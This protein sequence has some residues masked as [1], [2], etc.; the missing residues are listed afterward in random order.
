MDWIS[1]L[2]GLGAVISAVI[3]TA[4]QRL[5]EKKAGVSPESVPISVD[6]KLMD[7]ALR[8]LGSIQ[9]N[10]PWWKTTIADLEALALRPETFCKPTVRDWLSLSPVREDLKAAA[11]AKLNRHEI[12]T[13]IFER[14]SDSYTSIETTGEDRRFAEG[15]I[16]IAVAYLQASVQSGVRDPAMA[17]LVQAT[18]TFNAQKIQDEVATLAEV[19]GLVKNPHVSERFTEDAQRD[20]DKILRRRASPGQATASD[21]RNLRSDFGAGRRLAAADRSKEQEVRYWL[22]RVEAGIGHP[23]VAETMLAQLVSEGFNVPE[24]AWGLV[25]LGKAQPALALRRLRDLRDMDRF[26]AGVITRLAVSSSCKGHRPAQSLPLFLSTTPESSTR[27]C[28]ETSS[29]SRCTSCSGMRAMV[30]FSLV[31]DIQRIAKQFDGRYHIHHAYKRQS[32]L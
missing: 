22:A 19:A 29:F 9:A 31:A 18:A 17:A 32:P 6:E 24:A 21:L 8:R 1:I 10:D 20:L 5:A 2:K 3:P 25:E 26:L 7:D 4:K 27:R 16:K 13:A 23:E 15:A 11:R 30:S 14:L 12:P 28:T